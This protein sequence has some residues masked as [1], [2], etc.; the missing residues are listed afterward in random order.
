MRGAP[1]I[2]G[3]QAQETPQKHAYDCTQTHTDTNTD[4]HTSSTDAHSCMYASSPVYSHALSNTTRACLGA[5]AAGHC[6]PGTRRRGGPGGAPPRPPRPAATRVPGCSGPLSDIRV[7]LTPAGPLSDIRVD[8]T[9][10]GLPSDVRVVFRG[11]GADTGLSPESG[12]KLV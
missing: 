12:D 9:P 7:V 6:G 5:A 8:F 4:T 10:A 11:R 1:S 3:S 2:L